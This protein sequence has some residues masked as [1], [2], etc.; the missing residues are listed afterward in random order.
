[1]KLRHEEQTY[2]NYMKRLHTSPAKSEKAVES[3]QWDHFTRI[4]K[5]NSD[6]MY[7]YSPQFYA[8]PLTLFRAS[9]QAQE[10][11]PLYGWGELAAQVESYQIPGE[12]YTLIQEPYVQSL[13]AQLAA[14]LQL[15]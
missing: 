12:H 15:E 3:L 8:S 11:L 4:F 7:D 5:A 10:S 2:L 9:E 1:M 13:A 6:A 14:K